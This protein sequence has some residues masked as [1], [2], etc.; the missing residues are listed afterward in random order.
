[1]SQVVLYDT[2]FLLDGRVW[3]LIVSHCLSFSFLCFLSLAK[4]EEEEEKE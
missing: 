3:D 1:M 2:L 4:E